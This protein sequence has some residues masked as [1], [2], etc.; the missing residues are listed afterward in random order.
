MSTRLIYALTVALTVAGATV[1]QAEG[2]DPS[3][4]ATRYPG[5][6][7]KTI[8][9]G[10]DPDTP[11]YAQR[12]P[13]NME[14]MTGSDIDLAK[15]VLE[16][17]GLKYEFVPGAWS[18]LMPAIVSGQIDMMS[19]L[20]YNPKRAEQVDFVVYMKAGTGA[21]VQKGNPAKIKSNDDLCGKRV[22]VSLG[23]VEEAQMRELT[24]TCTKAGHGAIEIQTYPDNASGFRLLQNN[25]TDMVLNDLALIDSTAKQMPAVFE[26]AYAIVSGFQLG[27]AAKKGND[28]LTQALFD[29]LK[30]VQASG[31][32]VAMLNKYGIDVDLILPAEVKT[33]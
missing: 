10:V 16:C 4:A 8:R 26:R 12:D 14:K 9:M 7:G 24:T 3:H 18:G 15:A 21:L 22:A 13:A 2:C 23:S 27:L 32:H 6:A 5:L 1:A 19:Y 33:K 29:G 25:R 20:Y 31:G 11:P 28:Q 17:V 30:A